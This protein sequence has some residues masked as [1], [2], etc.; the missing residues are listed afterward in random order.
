VVCADS[1]AESSPAAPCFYRVIAVTF[2]TNDK[3]SVIDEDHPLQRACRGG[4]CLD[5]F[6]SPL[7]TAR[8]KKNEKRAKVRPILWRE[9][10]CKIVR[11]EGERGRERG[12]V[13]RCMC[14]GVCVCTY[15]GATTK[16]RVCECSDVWAA[17]STSSPDC[18]AFPDL[19]HIPRQS[20]GP[21]ADF[22]VSACAYNRRDT[23]VTT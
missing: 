17:F 1:G 23:G 10:A 5:A 15:V 2:V 4:D 22:G 11:E 19:H 21:L 9:I 20:L 7:S 13:C 3:G 18:V 16:E 12:R 8:A 6:R 14:V